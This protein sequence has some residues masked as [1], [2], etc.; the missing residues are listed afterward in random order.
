MQ[1]PAPPTELQLKPDWQRNVVKSLNRAKRGRKVRTPEEGRNE[2]GSPKANT[3]QTECGTT[4]VPNQKHQKQKKNPV[5]SE[6]HTLCLSG[7]PLDVPGVVRILGA[8]GYR[9]LV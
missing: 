4:K 2:A 1:A 6:G 7:T 5:S 3:K 8:S 9:G